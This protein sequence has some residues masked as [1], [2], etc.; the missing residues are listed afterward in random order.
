MMEHVVNICISLLII[1]CLPLLFL[2]ISFLPIALIIPKVLKNKTLALKVFIAVIGF[3]L[4]IFIAF[5]SFLLFDGFTHD[6]NFLWYLLI[7]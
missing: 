3:I 6:Y 7:I 1:G 5:F 2:L 4:S